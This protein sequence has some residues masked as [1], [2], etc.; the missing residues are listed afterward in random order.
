LYRF[1][2]TKKEIISLV[3][4]LSFL[5]SFT[6]STVLPIQFFLKFISGF[7]EKKKMLRSHGFRLLKQQY[8]PRKE[9]INSYLRH[10]ATPPRVEPV[11]IRLPEDDSP[12]LVRSIPKWYKKDG[13]QVQVGD[14]LCEVDAGDVLY[15]FN[16]PVSGWLVRI[17]AK[18]GSKDLKGGEVIAFLAGAQDQMTTVA[19]EAAKEIAENKVLEHG[20]VTEAEPSQPKGELSEWLKS[21][22]G[23]EL[24]EYTDNFTKEGFTSVEALKTLEEADLDALSITK[25]GHRKLLLAAAQTLNK[26]S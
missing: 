10:F 6:T 3:I 16:S 15:D 20:L 4:S 8:Q 12:G 1:L 22:G 19:Y 9:I 25:R 11:R 5:N 24:L 17:L 21:V 14:P 2:I 7:L 13:E 26:T 23:E 18:E